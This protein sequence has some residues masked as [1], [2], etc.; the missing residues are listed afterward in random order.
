MLDVLFRIVYKDKENGFGD[1][2]Y[3]SIFGTNGLNSF[4]FDTNSYEIT[5]IDKALENLDIQGSVI[6]E[7]DIIDILS[8][9]TKKVFA[10]GKISYDKLS[11][12]YIIV[13]KDNKKL[14]FNFD[15]LKLNSLCIKKIGN[16]YLDPMLLCN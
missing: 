1:M 2:I 3:T 11:E 12:A 6:Y 14:E 16:I 10:T 13:D 15:M 4:S 9:S 8:I 7:N 5:H